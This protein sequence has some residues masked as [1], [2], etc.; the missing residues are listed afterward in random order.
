MNF[1]GFLQSERD[2]FCRKVDCYQMRCPFCTKE[3]MYLLKYMEENERV[4]C[5][6]CDYSGDFIAYL[7]CRY[8]LTADQASMMVKGVP[9]PKQEISDSQRKEAMERLERNSEEIAAFKNVIEEIKK[10]QG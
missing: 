1:I 2:N 10:M 4:R 7:M 3:S 8:L 5:L 9:I 6:N